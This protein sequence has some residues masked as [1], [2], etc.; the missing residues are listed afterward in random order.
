MTIR[1]KTGIAALLAASLVC[2]SAP[3]LALEPSLAHPSDMKLTTP[4]HTPADLDLTRRIRDALVANDKVTTLGKNV[5][6]DARDGEVTLKGTVMTLSE[7][8]LV[9]DIASRVA[10]RGKVE[11]ELEFIYVL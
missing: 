9:G 5:A 4:S 11:N 8:T 7:R 10:G 3:L 6:I 2:T 1:R